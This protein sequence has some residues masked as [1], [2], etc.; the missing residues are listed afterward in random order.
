[1]PRINSSSFTSHNLISIYKQTAL[2]HIY[3]YVYE[4]DSAYH[5]GGRW[6][7]K[8][9]R[10]DFVPVPLLLMVYLLVRK[11]ICLFDGKTI[12]ISLHLAT[13]YISGNNILL[14]SDKPK[15]AAS[16]MKEMASNVFSRACFYLKLTV[17]LTLFAAKRP[18]IIACIFW[19]AMCG[20][21]THLNI[22]YSK[23]LFT[24]C[25]HLQ[26]KL[27]YWSS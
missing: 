15:L 4:R 7:S 27:A 2:V 25:M 1:M 16:L 8:V 10:L 24:Q 3:L 9:L 14:L 20:Y 13:V 23:C 22:L 12:I 21:H 26:N 6:I 5:T 19:R 11:K 18:N 17:L